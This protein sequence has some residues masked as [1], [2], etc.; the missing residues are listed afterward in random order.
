MDDSHVSNFMPTRILSFNAMNL[1]RVL[2]SA[3]DAAILRFI[4]SYK[5]SSALYSQLDILFSV[6]ANV[7]VRGKIQLASRCLGD[8]NGI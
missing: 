8:C 1:W 6:R 7:A 4:I 5:A 3:V 2:L